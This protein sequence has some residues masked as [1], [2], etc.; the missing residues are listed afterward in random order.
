M[1]G[2][3]Q[4]ASSIQAHLTHFV[5]RTREISYL[6]E[7]LDRHRLVTVT[8]AGGSGKTRLAIEAASAL[9]GDTGWVDLAPA[10]DPD[11]VAEHVAAT[12]GVRQE[13]GVATEGRLLDALQGRALLLVLDNCE[14][15]LHPVATLAEKLLQGCPALR[16]LATSREALGVGGEVAWLLPVLSLPAPDAVTPESL[17]GSEAVELFVRR[18]RDVQPS[19]CLHLDNAGAVGEICRR[20]DGLPLAIELAAARVQVLSPD[21]IASRLHDRFRLLTTRSRAVLPRHRTLHEVIA[22]SYDQL[23]APEGQALRA[24]SVFV[25][26]FSLEAAEAVC[27]TDVLDL[28]STLAAKSL[29]MVETGQRE[30][31]YR[32]LETVRQFG[33][34]RLREA[35]DEAPT[36]R[37]HA[38]FF[39]DEAVARERGVF[40][41]G[42]DPAYL[43][44][45]DVELSELRSAAE[46]L[47]HE[48][49]G[50]DGLRLAATLEWFW[51][52]RGRFPEGRQ[53]LSAA[54][55]RLPEGTP[56]ARGKARAALALLAFS[57]GDLAAQSEAAE[58][59]VE[60][61]RSAECPGALAHA[62]SVLGTAESA[63]GSCERANALLGEAVDLARA[64]QAVELV[65]ILSLQGSTSAPRGD[66]MTAEA[67]WREAALLS[68]EYGLAH[69]EVHL[70]DALGRVALLRGDHEQARAS[71][72][73][74]LEIRLDDP[75]C[76]ALALSGQA[77]VATIDGEATRATEILGCAAAARARIGVPLRP[78]ETAVQDLLTAMARERLDEA[79]Y[80][81]A[82]ARGWQQDAGQL[83]EAARASARSG[84]SVASAILHDP[85][86]AV[87][88][89]LAGGGPEAVGPNPLEGAAE[90]DLA[91]WS[92]GPLEVAI[93]GTPLPRDS[94]SRGKPVELLVHLLCHP[95]GRTREQ[96]GLEFWPDASATQVK[97]SFHVLLHRLRG[98]LGDTSL[99]VLDDGRYRIHPKRTVWFDAA[100]FEG[101]MSRL[102]KERG[103]AT[104]ACVEGLLGLYRGHFMEE[105]A[106]GDWSLAVH[107]RL[108]RRYVEGLDLL[109]DLRIEQGDLEAAIHVLERLVAVEDLREDAYRRLMVCLSGMG[110]RDRALRHYARLV[111]QLK[112]E[113]DAHP[114]S[115]TRELADR[116]RA[117]A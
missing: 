89:G 65:T 50:D 9:D 75:W 67:S 93:A 10:H 112:D 72:I 5:G 108:R 55:R 35:G 41:G 21:Q 43:R 105:G 94:L 51:F 86:S 7:L 57:Q 70:E 111:V 60:E 66:W 115:S 14:H 4:R 102:L 3:L 49:C 36:R 96:I 59:A 46:W 100:V 78:D 6:G 33:L 18:A 26:G 88:P 95:D 34:D 53:W 8:G 92:L 52:V 90:A 73:R 87:S 98:S 42:S 11:L 97:N 104:A 71:F 101:S 80:A 28:L 37:C 38:R 91:V 62:L 103:P 68:R 58:A 22:W 69:S 83:L 110:H 12:L 29:L 32:L 99:I 31:R 106:A 64:A 25:G 45:F 114:E 24:L 81:A 113:L 56:L 74:T 77:C 19:F 17:A 44:W 116:I 85:V 107:D 84:A 13:A 76:D 47:D 15:L 63:S 30:A 40:A 109:A 20:L 117:S 1:S 2:L 61:L 39:V 27:A 82:W 23:D 48:P 16:I 54:L 79:A